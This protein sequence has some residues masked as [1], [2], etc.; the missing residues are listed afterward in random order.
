MMEIYKPE[1]VLKLIA[2]PSPT[3]FSFKTSRAALYAFRSRYKQRQ[4]A[5]EKKEAKDRAVSLMTKS[6]NPTQAFLNIYESLLHVKALTAAGD[7]DSRLADLEQLTAT[8]T[9]LRKQRHAESK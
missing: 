5:R 4:A 6:P 1:A 2:E 7:P 8:I 9:K 3:G